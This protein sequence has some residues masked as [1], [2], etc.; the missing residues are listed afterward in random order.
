[1]LLVD[2]ICERGNLIIYYET[3][4]QILSFGEDKTQ[5]MASIN[6][7]K[8]CLFL[9][10]YAF[11][12]LLLHLNIQYTSENKKSQTFLLL[13][14]SIYFAVGTNIGLIR[15]GHIYKSIT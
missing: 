1:M 4:I 2:W 3:Y 9:W 8:I 14:A 13:F 6:N 15:F 5:F 7:I 11:F 10:L 12:W